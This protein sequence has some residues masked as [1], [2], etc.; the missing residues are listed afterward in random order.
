M[1]KN[2]KHHIGRCIALRL[3]DEPDV[4]N[5]TSLLT[6]HVWFLNNSL[7][8]DTDSS[9]GALCFWLCYTKSPLVLSIA[10]IDCE[11]VAERNVALETLSAKGTETGNIDPI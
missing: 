10:L 7:S 1:Q 6:K 5:L 9:D 11:T 8:N 2:E 3:T 4:V